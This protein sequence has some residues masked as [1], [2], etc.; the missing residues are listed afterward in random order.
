MT[1]LSESLRHRCR[2]LFDRE[3]SSSHRERQRLKRLPRYAPATTDL[4]GF[5]IE[6]VDARS[7]LSMATEIFQ[8]QIYAFDSR[9]EPVRI[10]DAG[11]NI[12]VSTLYFKRR[13]PTSRVTAFEPDAH[14]FAVLQRNLERNGFR[15][16]DARPVAVWCTDCSLSFRREGADAGRI[17][18][19]GPGE[20]V[21]AVRLR[22]FLMEK[23]DLLKLDIEGAEFSVLR[24]CRDMLCN[25]EHLFVE[26]HSFTDKDQDLPELLGLL[27]ASGFRL[28]LQPVS[29]SE[30]P[31][32]RRHSYLGMDMQVNV[33]A[34]R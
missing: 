20:T 9:S 24:D 23:I 25:V 18:P 6:L 7:F 33:F 11:A 12:G 8:R 4:L 3:Y 16:V 29:F 27:T 13:F 10:I 22:P 32:L 1:S 30:R 19:T 14:I 21:T 26:Y 5:P 2:L 17:F 31:F 15:D 34:S 28:H